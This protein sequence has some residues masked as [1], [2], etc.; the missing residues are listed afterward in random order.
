M[1]P[2]RRH[3]FP[4]EFHSLSPIRRTCRSFTTSPP[5][6]CRLW[7]TVC[8]CFDELV[9]GMGWQ[10]LTEVRLSS[11]RVH[12][13]L[14]LLCY[15]L[16]RICR[17]YIDKD[18]AKPQPSQTSD[19]TGIGF[20]SSSAESI[21]IRSFVSPILSMSDVENDQQGEMQARAIG[22]AC[23][24]LLLECACKWLSFSIPPFVP[25]C[26]DEDD[27]RSLSS[28]GAAPLASLNAGVTDASNQVFSESEPFGRIPLL[29]MP[30]D[31]ICFHNASSFNTSTTSST[32]SIKSDKRKISSSTKSPIYL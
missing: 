30:S 25:H 9:S 21:S 17:K 24:T 28:T 8:E 11:H 4:G 23:T 6:M 20:R 26:H 32:G 14:P 22:V 1:S 10:S 27:S 16:E 31:A 29:L 5:P 13:S 2:N 15:R 3:S 7:Q 12:S 18:Y 19:R